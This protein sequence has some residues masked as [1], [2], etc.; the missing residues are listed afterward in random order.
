MCLVVAGGVCQG[1]GESKHP[2]LDCSLRTFS[3]EKVPLF[4]RPAAHDGSTLLPV[5]LRLCATRGFPPTRAGLR[6][7]ARPCARP[8]SGP[9]AL[10]ITAQRFLLSRFAC[11]QRGSKPLRLHKPACRP[12]G[13]PVRL[14]RSAS[15]PAAHHG[16][17]LLLNT[18]R[19]SRS[20]SWPACRSTRRY[21]PGAP[22]RRA[23]TGRSRP[24]APSSSARRLRR[25]T[26]WSWRSRRRSP[27]GP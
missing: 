1:E 21:R 23:Y 7:A 25:R 26:T 4:M 3:H 19:P 27:S 10:R 20:W 5:T 8:R 22:A 15:Q 18:R 9:S 11:A 13:P 16:S 17:A 6:A 2:P 12:Y 14:F 24:P